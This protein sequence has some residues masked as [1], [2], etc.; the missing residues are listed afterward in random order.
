MPP[1]GRLP[2]RDKSFSGFLV[3]YENGSKIYEKE[4]YYSKKLNKKCATNWP[5]IDKSKISSLELLWRG[6]SK[7]TITRSPSELHKKE[8]S[9][10]DWFFSQRAYFDM[11]NRKT[12]LISRNIGYVEDDIIHITSIMEKT[13]EISR[14]VRAVS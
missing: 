3:T 9:A 6:E 7:V 5:E 4:N 14:S 13:G 11:T 12:I 8:L 1:K 10:K 2:K